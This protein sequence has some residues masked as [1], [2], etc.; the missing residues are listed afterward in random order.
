MQW[1]N[2]LRRDGPA[3]E[4]AVG[5]AGLKQ[6]VIDTERDQVNP[7]L[8]D[9]RSEFANARNSQRRLW[10]ELLLN[11]EGMKEISEALLM[12]EE[13]IH[14]LQE[15]DD[16]RDD[17]TEE[18]DEDAKEEEEG[19]EEEE[20][21]G[22]EDYETE[23]EPEENASS[24]RRGGGRRSNP[25]R[26][27]AEAAEKNTLLWPN[28]GAREAWR[29]ATQAAATTAQGAL[30]FRCL[31]DHAVDFGAATRETVNRGGGRSSRSKKKQQRHAEAK[32]LSSKWH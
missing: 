1:R 17:D 9:L 12:L 26:A 14:E 11:A 32:K 18:E 20:E 30:A 19:D 16:I 7:K 24:S 15:E 10:M 22:D 2:K 28:L 8:Q 13:V 4:F 21:G 5:L 6:S 25:S 3:S 29:A 31:L 27:A 23:S